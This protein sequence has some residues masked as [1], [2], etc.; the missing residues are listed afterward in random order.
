MSW[1]LPLPRLRRRDRAEAELDAE[2][3]DHVKRQA[4]DYVRAGMPDREARRRARLEFGG[5]DQVKEL[6][7]DVRRTRW[8]ED[9]GRDLRYAVRRQLKDRSSGVSWFAI[10]ALAIGM[11]AS[12]AMF[13]VLDAV[14]LQPL[15]FAQE[16]RLVAGWKTSR[17][18]PTRFIE[19]SYPEFLQWQAQST[20]FE[21]VGLAVAG[22]TGRC[23][24]GGA[25]VSPPGAGAR[26]GPA[27]LRLHP[28]GTEA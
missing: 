11:G 14:V 22:R 7:R 27:G 26:P 4:A 1:R 15:P 16:Q 6:C 24:A 2:L 12:T 17:T 19:L 3:R 10:A 18:D 5:L 25:V 8:L 21:R 13:G 20:S 28:P 23:G 9:L